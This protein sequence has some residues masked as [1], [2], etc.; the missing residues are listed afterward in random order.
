MSKSKYSSFF[1][2]WKEADIRMEREEFILQYTSGRTGSLTGLTA[3]ELRSIVAYLTAYNLK[4][5]DTQMDKLRKKVIA[6]YR[7]KYP[8]ASPAAAKKWAE[9]QGASTPSGTIVRRPFNAYTA[10]ELGKII[11]A[12]EAMVIEENKRM[13]DI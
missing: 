4:K 12:A 8:E 10:Y 3:T 2:A 5:V 6:T 13:A 1:A 7:R 9:N 11:D